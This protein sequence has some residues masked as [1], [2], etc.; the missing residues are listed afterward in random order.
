MDG[1]AA[2][3]VI[4]K[5]LSGV[6]GIS[7]AFVFGSLAT[8]TERNDSDVDLFVIGR[9][10]GRRVAQ[11]TRGIS[12]NALGRVLN[13]MLY[14]EEEMSLRIRDRNHFVLSVLAGPKLFV[15]GNEKSLPEYRECVPRESTQP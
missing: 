10:D 6:D 9:I 13:W 8:G 3:T 15:V 2:A 11:A 7:C 1:R 5:A 4:T 14:T 12:D